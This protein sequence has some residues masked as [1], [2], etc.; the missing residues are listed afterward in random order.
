[1]DGSPAYLIS[2]WTVKANPAISLG[3]TIC[4]S[5]EAGFTTSGK[6]LAMIGHRREVKVNS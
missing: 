3:Y 2:Y 1:M 5:M 6:T 4:H